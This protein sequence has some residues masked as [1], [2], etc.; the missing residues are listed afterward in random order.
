MTENGERFTGHGHEWRNADLNP[1]E[2]KIATSWVEQR[3]DK[4]AML[5]NKEAIAI[6]QDPTEQGRKVQDRGLSE[7]WA[8][9]LMGEKVA[10]LLLN[11][12][13]YSAVT[14]N[15]DGTLVGLKGKWSAH[16]VYTGEKLTV[17]DNSCKAEVPP[18]SSIF[19][20]TE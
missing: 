7:I 5:T 13:P 9:K 2:A 1:E 11:R 20:I 15:L 10:V 17:K 19:F 6:N 16:N 3:I 18:G 8:K 4:R 12:N 14:I